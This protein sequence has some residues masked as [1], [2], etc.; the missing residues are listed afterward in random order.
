MKRM[1]IATLLVAAGSAQAMTFTDYATVLK[2]EPRYQT[3]KDDN[4]EQ[5][6]E[7]VAAPAPS[8][9]LEGMVTAEN[10]GALLGGLVGGVLGHQVGGGKGKT[11]ATIVGAIGGAMAGQ[12]IA[13]NTQGARPTTAARTVCHPSQREEL[14]GYEVTYEYHGQRNTVTLPSD[15]GR[16]LKMTVNAQPAANASAANTTNY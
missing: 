7:P 10:G 12:Q 3:V 13:R 16:R 15:P 14:A 6:N 2:S 1:L 5:V 9:G 8:G 4:C 11:A